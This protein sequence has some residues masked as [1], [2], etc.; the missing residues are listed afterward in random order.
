M[1]RWRAIYL[2]NGYD[3]VWSFLQN[4][5]TIITS[6]PEGANAPSYPNVSLQDGTMATGN[7]SARE[8]CS[9]LDL[10]GRGLLYPSGPLADPKGRGNSLFLL[11]QSLNN[12]LVYSLNNIADGTWAGPAYATVSRPRDESG[13]LLPSGLSRPAGFRDRLTAA[14]L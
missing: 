14:A 13:K 11:V 8:L 1:A 9:V 6:V 7:W 12:I 4:L 2:F 10:D 5:R 3:K